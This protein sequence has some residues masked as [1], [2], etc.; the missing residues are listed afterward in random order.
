MGAVMSGGR[1]DTLIGM[2]GK[3]PVPAVGISLGL[4]RLL[5]A[6]RE[7][8]LV[9][10]EHANASVYVTVF[11]PD[12]A[13]ASVAAARQLRRAGISAEIDTLGG[14]LG[15]QFKRGH[16]RGSR[17]VLVAGPDDVARGE[18]VVKDLRAS[19]QFTVAHEALA[20][21]VAERLQG[22]GTGG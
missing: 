3:Q 21:A 8:K 12:S 10:T 17:F 18:V 2:F 11:D 22:S 20:G 4:D 16:K 19:E 5:A 9:A 13:P 15:K 6:L 14:K 1:Y 7:L